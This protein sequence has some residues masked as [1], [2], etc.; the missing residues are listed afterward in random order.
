MVFGQGFLRLRNPYQIV[1]ADGIV[2]THV[3]INGGEFFGGCG[4]AGGTC[5]GLFF[6]V[7]AGV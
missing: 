7:F 2:F 6:G 1:I 3:F 5:G 4:F